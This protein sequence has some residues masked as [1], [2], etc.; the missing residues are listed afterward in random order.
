MRARKKLIACEVVIDAM[1][2]FLP[3]DMETETLPMSLHAN[4]KQLR[5]KLQQRIDELDGVYD[6]IV[7]GFGLCS[8]ATVGLRASHSRLVMAR[9]DD[10][11]G[12]FLGSRDSYRE[13]IRK[14][15]GTYFLTRGWLGANGGTP[16]D[17]HERAKER[18]GESRAKRLLNTMLRHYRRLVY[19][20]TA[21]GERQPE[22]HDQAREI[23][24]RHSL[25]YEE[26]EGKTD[27]IEQL[28]H[29]PWDD[30]CF[31]VQPGEAVRLDN[32]I[33]RNT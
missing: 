9:T 12:M 19:I 21:G 6:P 28:I 27:L 22:A 11:I 24:D 10:C 31:Q 20:N 32:F 5:H 15:P 2:A 26:L 13:Q 25:Q 7:L 8:Q 14:E 30:L 4:P 16:F 29:G 23:A 17:E 3:A 1:Q 18:W 33:S